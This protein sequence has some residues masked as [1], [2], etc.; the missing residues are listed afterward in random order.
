MLTGL[1]GAQRIVFEELRA[2]LMANE[3][4]S[5][6][7]LSA[8]SMYHP[9]TVSMALRSLQEWGMVRVTPTR[10]GCRNH[11]TLEDGWNN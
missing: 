2:M 11:Y 6:M 10:P 7:R 1:K 9:Y 4:V 3:P 8:R 5:I